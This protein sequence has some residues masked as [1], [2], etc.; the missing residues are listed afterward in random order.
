MP[1]HF[2][3]E[4]HFSQIHPSQQSCPALG[5]RQSM[6]S[7]WKVGT[8][9]GYLNMELQFCQ[10]I[11]GYFPILSKTEGQGWFVLLKQLEGRNKTRKDPKGRKKG[12]AAVE[13]PLFSQERWL[14]VRGIFSVLMLYSRQKTFTA[15]HRGSREQGEWRKQRVRE[16]ITEQEEKW[17]MEGCAVVRNVPDSRFHEPGLLSS[18]TTFRQLLELLQGT[19]SSGAGTDL[20]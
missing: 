12:R 13:G 8:V 6:N 14:E 16:G 17:E 1:F 3:E 20:L 9:F 4:Q 19:L 15:A 10:C 7:I 2:P 5:V 18:C 11:I